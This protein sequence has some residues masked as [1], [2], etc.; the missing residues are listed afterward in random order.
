MLK[1][2]FL[3]NSSGIL[4]SRILGFLRDIMM[5]YILGAGIYTDIF[6]TASRLPNLF[7]RVFAEGAF[8]Q[9]F[10]PS[11]VSSKHKG[12]FLAGIFVIFCGIIMILSL[13][14]MVFTPTI[15]KLLASGFSDTEI[16]IATPIVAINFW[17]LILIFCATFFSVILQYKHIF[18][19]GSYSSALL[20]LAMI[21][22]LFYARD[23][24]D[25]M[26]IYTL[27]YG[28][29]IGGVAQ[30]ALHFYPLYAHGL[31]RL[32]ALGFKKSK[33][34]FSRTQAAAYRQEIR[35][36]FKQFIPAIIGGSTIPILS[37][38]ETT[39][40][41]QLGAG[42]ISYLY[43][44]N[45]IFQLPLALFAIAISTALFPLVAKAIKNQEQTQAL[46][47][48]KN[49]FWFLCITLCVCTLGGIM[50]KDEIIWLLF[51]RGS[52]GKQDTQIVAN[53][54]ACYLIGLLPFGLS[55]IFSLWLYSHHLQ[56]KAAKFSVIALASGTA[57]AIASY[58][59]FG[60]LGIAFS[61]SCAGFIL[62]FLNAKAIGKENF[63]S[64][65]AHKK[66]LMILPIILLLEG[67]ILYG[68]KLL[69]QGYIQ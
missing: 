14:V 2:A 12:V 52:F 69:I 50:L 58:Q 29:L 35:H 26:I 28:V 40:A 32:L 23:E 6:T 25:L 62:L 51:E 67:L 47:A 45:R 38:I 19:V 60:V 68:F 56:G 7:R 44:A 27:S 42:S 49:A 34:L 16:A 13:I 57:I 9:S 54:F 65:I 10:F 33:I 11:F 41:S 31:L 64:I 46:K 3:T 53:V 20:N 66:A 61:S 1:K 18:W 48:M 21:L 8:T 24:E 63:L 43:Y 55:R 39:I 22:A 37:F 17:Y 15:T 36:F 5:A 30:I 59:T 4:L